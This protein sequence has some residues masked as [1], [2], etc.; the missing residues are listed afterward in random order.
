MSPIN[1]R[2]TRKRR[3]R[4]DFFM[5]GMT[6]KRNLKKLINSLASANNM[7]ALCQ[8]CNREFEAREDELEWSDVFGY[9]EKKDL[10]CPECKEDL[11]E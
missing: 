6:R 10:R 8:K 3:R 5:A 7:R 9:V 1:A 2:L 4:M 11:E